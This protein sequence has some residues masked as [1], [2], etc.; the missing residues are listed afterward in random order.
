LVASFAL[1]TGPPYRR[2]RIGL[3]SFVSF[4]CTRGAAR[5]RAHAVNNNAI[6]IDEA[7]TLSRFNALRRDLLDPAIA[8]HGGRVVKLMGEGALVQFASAVDAA[9][10][11]KLTEGLRRA[12]LAE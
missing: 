4:T 9:D 8:A 10:A 12:G 3:H 2:D 7:G 6:D 5:P 11:D 1:A